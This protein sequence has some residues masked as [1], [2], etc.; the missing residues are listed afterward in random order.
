VKT[1]PRQSHDVT[2]FEYL[3]FGPVW[4]NSI[5]TWEM[6]RHVALDRTMPLRTYPLPTT[7][8]LGE[9]GL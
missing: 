6:A 8:R 2:P 7:D 4:K 5:L 9:P 1:V 3:P